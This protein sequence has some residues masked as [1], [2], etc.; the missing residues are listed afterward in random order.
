MYEK[1]YYFFLSNFSLTPCRYKDEKE[2]KN[3]IRLLEEE[4][5]SKKSNRQKTKDSISTMSSEAME[6]GH[7]DEEDDEFEELQRKLTLKNIQFY[8]EKSFD[9][10]KSFELELDLLIEFQKN[11]N[12]GNDENGAFFSPNIF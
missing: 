2:L 8:I 7:D 5:E 10:I 1:I 11:Q 6:S 4:M 3:Q 9:D 12:L